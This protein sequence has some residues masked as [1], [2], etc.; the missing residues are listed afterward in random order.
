MSSAASPPSPPPTAARTS[1]SRC[2]ASTR[3]PRSTCS[4]PRCRRCAPPARGSLVAIGAA[5]AQRAPASFGP[6]AASKAAVLRLVE[7]FAAELK[8]DGVRVNAVLPGTMDTPQNRAA[9]PDVDPSA[10]GPPRGGRRDHRLPARP[11][12]LRDHR[13]GDPGAG[14]NLTMTRLRLAHC[15]SA[16]KLVTDDVHSVLRTSGPH[17]RHPRI[18]RRRQER[19]RRAPARSRPRARSRR[20][21]RTPHRPR[22]RIAHIAV[23]QRLPDRVPPAAARQPARPAARRDRSSRAPAAP[24]RAGDGEPRQQPRQRRRALRLQRL[25]PEE[26]RVAPQ[27]H[28]EAEPRH[29]R[30][31]IR[32]DVRAPGAIALLQPQRLDGPVA[33]RRP[34]RAPR[35]PP[36]ARR[37]PWPRTR[38]ARAAPSRAR[39]T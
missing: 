28:R 10:L 37:R 16:I 31:M 26:R 2:S 21:A 24:R 9:M 11:R 14:P 27:L 4:A 38:P 20:P 17:P 6:Y 30:R 5:A 3:S 22:L 23:A 34:A 13:R 15:I 39:P 25:A 35:P 29:Q 7:A 36:S 18:V 8:A 12:L 33:R 1:G 19:R 32:P